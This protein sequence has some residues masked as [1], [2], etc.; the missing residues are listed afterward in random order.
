[1]ATLK[2]DFKVSFSLT[3]FLDYFVY[4]SMLV[5]VDPMVENNTLVVLNTILGVV[6]RCGYVIIGIMV[7]NHG[8]F[9]HWVHWRKEE[10]TFVCVL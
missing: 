3:H 8:G 9:G 1:M 7:F 6:L 10:L 2:Y 4:G 5:W